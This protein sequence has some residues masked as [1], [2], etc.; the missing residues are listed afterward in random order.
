MGIHAL[1]DGLKQASFGG[2]VLTEPRLL[3]GLKYWQSRRGNR[4]APSRSDI[5]PVGL[6]TLLP[7]IYLIDVLPAPRQFRMRLVG[8][9]V[10]ELAG[11]DFTG[12]LIDE[13]IYGE[14]TEMAI[15]QLVA[16]TEIK[17]PL[18]LRG[19]AFY[20]GQHAWQRFEALQLP[21][22][23]DEVTVDIIMGVNVSAHISATEQMHAPKANLDRFQVHFMDGEL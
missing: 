9:N 13:T 21:V 2:L 17:K 12:R 7:Y 23:N 20:E 15:D 19:F 14:Q 11:Q 5:D 8:T 10:R 6:R 4:W 1:E 18:L 16:L 3:D 22:S